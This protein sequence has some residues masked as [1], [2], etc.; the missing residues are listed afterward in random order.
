M[1]LNNVSRRAVLR[2]IGATVALPLLDVIP[3]RTIT[4]TTSGARRL[5]Y[6]YF[7]N[8]IAR[9]SWHPA[10]TDDAGRLLKLN[11]WMS[12]LEPFKDDLLIPK[13]IWTPLGNG[14]VGGTPTWLT[15]LDYNRQAINAG[16]H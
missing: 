7:P 14:H 10:K 3:Q 5:A 13:N 2:A 12:P 1:P 11:N 9:G 4:A 15:G 8:G 6:L 16:G